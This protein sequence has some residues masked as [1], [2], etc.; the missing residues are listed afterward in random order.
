MEENGLLEYAQLEA[1]AKDSTARF[2]ELSGTIKRAEGR[3]SEIAELQKADRELPKTREVY[4]AYRKAGYTKK[5][6]AAHES[7]I[8]LHKAAKAAFDKLG[9][10][11]LPH[12]KN[13]ASRVCRTAGRKEKSLCGYAA[14]KKEMQEVLTAKAN[15]DRLLSP[16]PEKPEKEKEQ[17]QR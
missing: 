4:A 7:E 15:V 2:N 10:Q 16:E 9:L 12:H 11:K 14:A 13:A 17:A 6:L 5:F 1:R 3:M 8:L